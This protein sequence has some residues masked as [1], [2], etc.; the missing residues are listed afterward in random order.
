MDHG[1][2]RILVLSLERSSAYRI[3]VGAPAGFGGDSVGASDLGM[4][5]AVIERTKSCR[6]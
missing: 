3:P 1:P 6:E 4:G 5:V 2:V